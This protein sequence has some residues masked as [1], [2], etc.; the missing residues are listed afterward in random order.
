MKLSKIFVTLFIVTMSV[1]ALSFA[2]DSHTIF[3]Q[4]FLNSSSIESPLPGERF[5]SE[6]EVVFEIS[7]DNGASGEDI[8]WSS[9]IDGELGCGETVSRSDLSVGAHDITVEFNGSSEQITIRLFSDLWELY[10]AEQAQAEIDRILDDF[11]FVFEDSDDESWDDVGFEFYDEEAPALSRLPF[12]AKL[13]I[14]RKQQFSEKPIFIGDHD[15]IYDWVK[16]T[17]DTIEFRLDC[18]N[19]SGGGGKVSFPR[20]LSH[21]GPISGGGSC[22][23]PWEDYYKRSY[24]GAL[25]L[26]IHEVRHN[27]PDDPGHITFERR[28]SGERLGDSSL[29]DGSGFAWAAKYSMWVYEY[30]LFDPESIRF[31]YV[32]P[33]VL[34][35]ARAAVTS[36]LEVIYGEGE[37]SHSDPLVQ[38][39]LDDVRA[40]ELTEPVDNSE[41]VP[42]ILDLSW[43]EIPSAESYSIQIFEAGEPGTV[44]SERP[45]EPTYR[46]SSEDLE[47]HTTYYWRVIYDDGKG[48]S[49]WSDI[50]AFTTG[51]TTTPEVPEQVVLSQPEDESENM[52]LHPEL[53]WQETDGAESYELIVSEHEDLSDPIVEETGFEE[54][55]YEVEDELD[56]NVTYYWAVRGVNQG[57]DGDWSD[58]WSFT[59]I[60]EIYPFTLYA[61]GDE[62][63]IDVDGQPDD[64]MEFFWN[65]SSSQSDENITYTWQFDDDS[66]FE[67]PMWEFDSDNDGA[68]STLT[69]TYEEMDGML[70]DQGVSE[71]ESLQGEWQVEAFVEGVSQYAEDAHSVTFRRGTVTSTDEEEEIPEE[72]AL[73]NNYPNPFNP[74]TQ[75]SYQLPEQTSV[76]LEVYSILGQHVKTLVNESQSAGNYEVSFDGSDVSSGTYIYRLEAGD[77]FNS[78]QMMLVK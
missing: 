20:R 57:G 8:C 64:E 17:I 62:L 56:H 22:G 75:I 69:F 52:D 73:G 25:L 26:F 6:E 1:H 28:M 7:T 5:V 72:F 43:E 48:R 29:E 60:I 35:N 44:V 33:S 61:P 24:H 32:N 4:D 50:W 10:Q 12:I 34:E 41:D 76:T 53:K 58:T 9:D 59:T 36:Q 71:G 14:L 49:L 39:I 67:D 45:S 18:G 55:S 2:N 15:T 31:G 77:Y 74:I 65:Y 30:S 19:A 37:P 42:T 63:L 66:E 21:W 16:E 70:S 46:T 68:D 11:N 47:P 13:D 78:K 40:P 38:T 3:H 23:E 27:E 54:T 51:Q